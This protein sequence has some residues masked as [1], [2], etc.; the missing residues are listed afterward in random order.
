M[1]YVPISGARAVMMRAM[2]I[3]CV[4]YQDGRKLAEITQREIRSYVS[5]PDCFVWVA[6]RDADA[7]ELAEMQEEFDLHPLAV[8]RM[9]GVG[10]KTAAKLHARGIDRINEIIA[11]AVGWLI[12]LAIISSAYLLLNRRLEKR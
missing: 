6:L 9:W 1:G 11:K 8:E 7:V 10:P 12:L 3:S 4:A 5:R 2:L